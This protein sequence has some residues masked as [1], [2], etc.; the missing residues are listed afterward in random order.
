MIIFYCLRFQTPPTR[1]AR[2]AYLSL[3][4][5]VAQLYP[6]KLGSFLVSS[7]ELLGYSGGIQARFQSQSQSQSQSY[8]ATGDLPQISW[9]WR[10]AP[11]D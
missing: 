2:S 5:K 4:N 10:Q 11:W 9:S 8:F 1:R 6:Q 3:R 7:F